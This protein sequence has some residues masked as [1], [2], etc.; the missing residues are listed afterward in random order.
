MQHSSKRRDPVQ[1]RKRE[2]FGD[3]SLQLQGDTTAVAGEP[4]GVQQEWT[5]ATAR[6]QG[7]FTV[8]GTV[9]TGQETCK[10][11]CATTTKMNFLSSGATQ[12]LES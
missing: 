2:M 1:G 5:P 7:S 4:C 6:P 8:L 11:T 10:S 9:L 12:P 3:Q